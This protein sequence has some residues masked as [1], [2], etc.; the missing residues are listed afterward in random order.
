MKARLTAPPAGQTWKTYYFAGGQLIAMRELTSTGD[1]LYYLHSDHLGSTSL[2]TDSG[3]NVTARQNYYPF[4]QIRP[5]GTGTM[6][7]DIGFTGQRG[8]DSS[9]GSL[10]FFKA[11]YFSPA[12][13]RF[14]SADS[15]VPGAGNPQSLNRYSYGLNNPVKY[16]D[17]TGHYVCDE[18]TGDCSTRRWH[19][20][21]ASA[22]LT[23]GQLRAFFGLKLTEDAGQ[24][25]AAADIRNISE[26]VQQ[27]AAARDYAT[28]NGNTPT[29]RSVGG[30]FQNVM[31][32]V[33]FN[34]DADTGR[35]GAY[36]FT[37]NAGQ[38][39]QVYSNAPAGGLSPQNATHELGHAFAQHLGRRPYTDLG[40]EEITYVDEEGQV[41]HIA[42]GGGART[43]RG[44]EPYPWIQDDATVASP[45]ID[46]TH[47]DFADMFL[48]WA[49]NHFKADPAGAARYAWMTT[50][51][52]EWI[53]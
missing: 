25:W 15:I 7:T 13:G 19:R 12:V 21:G 3:G 8:H 1:A 34:R 31:G 6:P 24:R 32:S 49:Y 35:D 10:M 52:A 2:T 11:R 41:I 4:G 9:L 37:S 48:G 26:A 20:F 44:M 40:N 28:W 18:D 36:A 50:N 27:T 45:D 17:P 16:R 30:L 51:I 42:G 47:E 38:L 5:G 23:R 46:P 33:E 22:D 53:R 29:A 43:F 39:I 14:L